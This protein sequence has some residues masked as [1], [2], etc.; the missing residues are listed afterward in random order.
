[1]E[2]FKFFMQ[3]AD[4]LQIVVTFLF[5]LQKKSFFKVK[6]SIFNDNYNYD[7]LGDKY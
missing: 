4:Q 1:M 7:I 2:N 3:S 5:L 6:N